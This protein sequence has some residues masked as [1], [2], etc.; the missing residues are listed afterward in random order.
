MNEDENLVETFKG[1]V[2]GLYSE[3]LEKRDYEFFTFI[4][5][6]CGHCSW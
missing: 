1:T 2:C 6:S 3:K 5:P 4:F